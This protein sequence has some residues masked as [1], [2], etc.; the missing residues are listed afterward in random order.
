MLCNQSRYA[1]TPCTERFG[2]VSSNSRTSSN[3]A[4][5]LISSQ[6]CRISRRNVC[7][8]V[9]AHS[10]IS[11]GSNSAPLIAREQTV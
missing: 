7:Y 2:S 6:V 5:G 10:Y 8:S 1:S 4:P 3:V 9:H 11:V